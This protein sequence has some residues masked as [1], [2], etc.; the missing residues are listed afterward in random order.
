MSNY[1]A[2]DVGGTNI[3]YAI[4]D[5]K[6]NIYENGK[7]NTPSDSLDEF[8]KVIFK[9]I[10]AYQSDNLKGVAFSIP[11]KVDTSTG[12][13]YFGG[14]LTYLDTICFKQVVGEKYDLVVSV[15]NDAKAAA[16]AELWLGSLQNIK[17]GAVIVLGTGVGGGVI[18]D[19]KLRLGPHFQAGELSLS[20]LDASRSGFDKMTGMLGSAV[21]MI[22][23]V[24]KEL[25]HSDLTDGLTAF[26]AINA[27]N[28]KAFPIFQD[29]C[30]YIAYLILN[31]QSFFDLTT[32]AIGGG[33]SA[34]PIVLEEICNQY[35]EFINTN[36]ILKMNLPVIDILPAAFGNDANLFGALYT[37]LYLTN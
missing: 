17:D 12:T 28:E 11:G 16:L 34:Q 20:V 18:L 15:Q 4:M 30:R 2:I 37:L 35:H 9:I 22:K 5:E 3:K 33:I 13:V 8:W 29:Y 27:K 23:D 24:N 21:N 6:G 10:D 26:E 7:E 19:G 1:L 31:L 14:V 25:G 32:Y 36:Q